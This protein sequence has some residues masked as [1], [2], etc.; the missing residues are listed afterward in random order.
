MGTRLSA[1]GNRFCV[2]CTLH[3]KADWRLLALVDTGSSVTA[4]RGDIC[5][6]VGLTYVGGLPTTCVHGS[7]ASMPTRAH[8][9]SLAIGKV[10][11]R[12][13]VHGLGETWDQGVPVDAILGLDMLE[14]CHATLDWTR[15]A[16]VLSA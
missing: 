5:R 10:A 15:M 16:G 4:V 8:G 3:G 6:G 13:A 2:P 11:K 1:R 12:L 9:G 14:G 7:H